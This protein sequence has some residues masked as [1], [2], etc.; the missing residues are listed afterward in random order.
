MWNKVLFILFV[1]CVGGF[2]YTIGS[3][4]NLSMGFFLMGVV[5]FFGMGYSDK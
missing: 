4:E 5:L 1:L 2:G 3:H